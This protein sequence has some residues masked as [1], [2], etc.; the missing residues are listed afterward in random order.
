MKNF[1]LILTFALSIVA[2]SWVEDNANQATASAVDTQQAAT[3]GLATPSDSQTIVTNG[4]LESYLKKYKI[5]SPSDQQIKDLVAQRQKTSA[6]REVHSA[7][8]LP[9]PKAKA[10]VDTMFHLAH[11]EPLP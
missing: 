11:K 8:K 3:R 4:D 5:Q 2:C 10:L 1:L 6:I 9:L 7:T